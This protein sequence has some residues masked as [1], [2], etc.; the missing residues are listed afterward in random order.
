[1]GYKTEGGNA[2]DHIERIMEPLWQ[3]FPRASRREAHFGKCADAGKCLAGL[4][5]V[6]NIFAGYNA[7][8]HRGCFLGINMGVDRLCGCYRENGLW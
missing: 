2:F 3:V 6:F 1:M 8:T 7:M 5:G 4:K